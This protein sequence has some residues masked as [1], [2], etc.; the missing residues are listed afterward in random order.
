MLPRQI[1]AGAA[2]QLEQ[3]FGMTDAR[4]KASLLDALQRASQPRALE[5]IPPWFAVSLRDEPED[6]AAFVTRTYAAATRHRIDGVTHLEEVQANAAFFRSGL[7]LDL[8]VFAGHSTRLLS[9]A[10]GGGTTVHGFD[11][12]SGIPERWDVDGTKAGRSGAPGMFNAVKRASKGGYGSK[13][14]RNGVPINLGTNVEFHR[15]RTYDTLAPFLSTRLSTPVTLLVCDLDTYQG[16]FHAVEA[17][18]KHLVVNTTLI[19][20]EF[21]VVRSEFRALFDLQRKYGFEFEVSTLGHEV[22]HTNP[23]WATV[24]EG[25]DELQW[26]ARYRSHLNSLGERERPR[27]P[28]TRDAHLKLLSRAM[29]H[30]NSTFGEK[31]MRYCIDDLLP[32]LAFGNGHRNVAVRLGSLGKLHD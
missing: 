28:N 7:V 5:R 10:L 4:T 24:L 2:K 14:F 1:F 21:F 31:A 20:D 23:D 12:F 26:A 17:A 6:Y 29:K 25:T 11:T 3:N 15:G 16:C 13:L 32:V 30:A 27:V 22:M 9:H 19:F 18:R 8:G